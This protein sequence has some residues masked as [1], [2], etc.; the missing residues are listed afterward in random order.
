MSKR[1]IR[2]PP[3]KTGRRVRWTL[4]VSADVDG[5]TPRALTT[6]PQ[7]GEAIATEAAK[8][9]GG[10]AAWEGE[11]V[12]TAIYHDTRNESRRKRAG[13]VGRLAPPAAAGAKTAP[14]SPHRPG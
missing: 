10:P 4:E 13:S 9:E 5:R 11:N 12:H 6:A 8:V 14:G 3:H 2:I 7:E 1:V